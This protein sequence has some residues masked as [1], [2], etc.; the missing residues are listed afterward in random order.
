MLQP[1]LR[2]ACH[3]LTMFLLH[4][5]QC[6]EKDHYHGGAIHRSSPCISTVVARSWASPVACWEFLLN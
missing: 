1:A 3:T 6:I 4:F 2:E 5:N